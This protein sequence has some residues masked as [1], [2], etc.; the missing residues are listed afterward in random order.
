MDLPE[1]LMYSK[2]HLWIRVEEGRAVIGITDHAQEALGA[3][4]ADRA[5]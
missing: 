2:E 1:E 4:S 5:A 3:I